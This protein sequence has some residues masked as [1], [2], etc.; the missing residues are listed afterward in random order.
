MP[1]AV[2]RLL[3]DA[4]ARLKGLK[5]DLLVEFRQ[6]YVSAAIRRYGNMF[7]AGDC[8]GDALLNRVR[9]ANL[10]LTCGNA[11]VHSDMLEWRA[12]DTPENAARQI[13]ASLFGVIQ[14]SMI[15]DRLPE[16][17]MKMIRH[18]LAFSQKHRR[19]LLKGWF[20]PH[21]PES[22]YPIVESGDGEER[23][24]AVYNDA[25]VADAGAGDRSVV[26]VNATGLDRLT[27]RLAKAPKSVESYDTFGVRQKP[28]TLRAGVQ[29]VPVCRSG[30][31]Q[32]S[33]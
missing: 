13:L 14:Y 22:A 15:L 27:L 16:N 30:Y 29:N 28:P 26:I 6:P 33:Y 7:R 31:L 18:W 32:L 9:I 24:V 23:I 8:P 21:H 10:R 20:R 17:H 2:E 25:C 19:A 4:M 1:E 12:D 5:P 11:A 3:T